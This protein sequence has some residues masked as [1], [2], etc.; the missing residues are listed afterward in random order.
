MNV[1][2]G[3]KLRFYSIKTSHF[4]PRLSLIFN[5]VLQWELQLSVWTEM[6]NTIWQRKRT[7]HIKHI[8]QSGVI[9]KIDFEKAYDKVNW[10][11]L[12]QS[13]RMKG[14]SSKWIEWIKS[15]ISGGSVAVNINDEVGHYFQTKKGV[16]QGDPLS[17]IL[18]NI[19]AHMLMLFINRAKAKD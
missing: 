18:F 8:K 2:L 11:F 13:L 3:F 15:F 16:R 19:V 12:L 10:N 4:F 7:Y 5:C 9:L 14:F 1:T 17:P 6:P